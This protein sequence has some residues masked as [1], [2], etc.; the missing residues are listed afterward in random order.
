[1]T[2]EITPG[3]FFKW[4]GVYGAFTVNKDGVKAVAD[5]IHNQ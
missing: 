3:E 5:Y 2:H 1:M 4:Q